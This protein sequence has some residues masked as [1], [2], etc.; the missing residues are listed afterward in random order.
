MENIWE[1]IIFITKAPE[2]AKKDFYPPRQ[3]S[4]ALLMMED[5]L[6]L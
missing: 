1:K 5:S 2:E 6:F 3:L 4:K